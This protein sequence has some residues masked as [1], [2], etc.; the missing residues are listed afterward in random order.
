M[1]RLQKAEKDCGRCGAPILWARSNGHPLPLDAE[2]NPA[3]GRYVLDEVEMTTFKLEAG[4]IERA[5]ERSEK[6][7]VN[8]LTHCAQS[9]KEEE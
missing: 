3:T 1:S 6:L 9:R 7:Y 8:H 2:P 5:L 4:M